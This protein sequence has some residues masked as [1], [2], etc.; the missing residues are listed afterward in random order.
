MQTG[1]GQTLIGIT[2]TWTT[3]STGWVFVVA[4]WA[5]VLCLVVR[6]TSFA[7]RLAGRDPAARRGLLIGLALFAVA[8]VLRWILPE[9][10][11]YTFNDEFEYVA[12]ARRLA[13]SG[14]FVLTS[15]PPAIVFVG[16]QGLAWLGPTF[17]A[18]AGMVIL[19]A[20]LTVPVLYWVLRGQR[21]APPV[22][23]LSAVLLALAPL[24]VKHAATPSAEIVSLLFLLLA[25]GTF[26]EFLRAP[27]RVHALGFAVSLFFALT[28]RVENAAV[29]LLLA[30]LAGLWRTEASRPGLGSCALF[31][32]VLAAAAAYLPGIA[33][34]PDHSETWWK[35]GLPLVQRVVVNLGFWIGN[36]PMTRKLPLIVLVAGLVSAF[37]RRPRVATF[38]LAFLLLFSAIF[39][40]YGLNLSWVGEP[41]PSAE[42][43]DRRAGH[44]MFRFNVILLPAVTFFAASG[45]VEF[46]NAALAS[47]RAR[48]ADRGMP[49]VARFGVL[50]LAVAGCGG[51]DSSSESAGSG[52]QATVEETVTDGQATT[53]DGSTSTDVDLG[54][55]SKECLDFASVGAKVSEAF[56]ASGGSGGDLTATAEAFDELVD[57]APD[58][59]KDDLETLAGGIQTM[60]EA[61][62]GVD[63]SSG[64]TPSA[65]DL[66]KLQKAMSSVDSAALQQA[67]TN[68][69]AWVQQ[70]CSNG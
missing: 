39:A 38:W 6:G 67:S 17:D 69:E 63:L 51:D 4:S 28:S 9:R 31:A 70:N 29:I 12:A 14:L 42:W 26:Q 44:D 56:K 48:S 60:A 21:V 24:H 49:R 8:F 37:A 18:V 46:W 45:L 5:G 55:L 27:G 62:K 53:D 58:A 50:A 10:V 20:S 25:I 16:A 22:A 54:D 41:G 66:Q 35:S 23:L 15:K 36:E 13:D 64:Q 33:A 32:L 65:E 61:L 11:P 52:D 34:S 59:I 30:L 19:L 68:V 1:I 57:A 43:S 47:L 7:R 40:F 2:T 3:L